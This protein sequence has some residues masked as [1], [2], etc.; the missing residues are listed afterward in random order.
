[1]D[2]IPKV[3]D[4]NHANTI[5]DWEALARA[6]IVGV[7]H[8]ATQGTYFKDP[9]YEER[10]DSARQAGLLWGAYCFNTGEDPATQ[11]GVF[12]AHAQPDDQTLVALDFEDNFK[13]QMSLAEAKTFLERAADAL[14]RKPVLYSGNRIKDLLGDTEDEFFGSHRLW[15]PQYGPKAVVQASWKSAARQPWLWQFSDGGKLEGTGSLIDL[16]AFSGTDDELKQEWAS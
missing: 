8:K 14:G 9:K 12:L 15:L 16:N 11:V 7:I 2:Q 1:M 3:I 10:R 4:I 13:S 6:G 5:S